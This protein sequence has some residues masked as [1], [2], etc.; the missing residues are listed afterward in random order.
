MTLWPWH[1][2]KSYLVLYLALYVLLMIPGQVLILCIWITITVE[3]R[4]KILTEISLG[5]SNLRIICKVQKE[6]LKS[7][8]ISNKGGKNPE[9]FTDLWRTWDRHLHP[10]AWF[11]TILLVF[12]LI[13]KSLVIK[14]AQFPCN[15]LSFTLLHRSVFPFL[16]TQQT[17][18]VPLPL[19]LFSSRRHRNHCKN[20]L[21]FLGQTSLFSP[22]T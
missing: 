21:H 11:H 9:R 14:A 13:L 1:S 12:T 22:I 15:L 3:K 16:L 8:L 18:L 6:I 5:T 7:R 10:S 19:L 4:I 2:T 20:F 17:R